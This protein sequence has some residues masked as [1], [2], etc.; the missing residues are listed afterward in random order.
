MKEFEVQSCHWGRLRYSSLCRQN[1]GMLPGECLQSQLKAVAGI[2]VVGFPQGL[3]KLVGQ[4][5]ELRTR[6]YPG[7][8]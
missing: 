3:L 1:G 5:S 6:T 7:R 8:G 2:C 4:G